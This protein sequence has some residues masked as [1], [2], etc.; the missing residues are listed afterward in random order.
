MG[1]LVLV[2]FRTLS[3]QYRRIPEGINAAAVFWFATVA[4]WA[5]LWYGIFVTK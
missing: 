2:T 5:V 1:F 3:G 4:V